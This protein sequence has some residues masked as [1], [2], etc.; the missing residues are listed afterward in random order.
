MTKIPLH[1]I[2]AWVAEHVA[3]VPYAC[4]K[5]SW[6]PVHSDWLTTRS[7]APLKRIQY[8]RAL[9][10]VLKANH[11]NELSYSLK[12]KSIVFLFILTY[13][14]E[15]KFVKSWTIR[16]E[17]SA[18]LFYT[19]DGE[20]PIIPHDIFFI[21]RTRKNAERNLRIF[22]HRNACTYFA[23]AS[24]NCFTMWGSR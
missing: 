8:P 10:H 11:E 23:P 3:T 9:V 6:A 16:H 5:T 12:G 7:A 21:M 15:I 24:S 4:L 19:Y 13:Y 14:S 18:W 22:D 1:W 2:R 20:N 17:F